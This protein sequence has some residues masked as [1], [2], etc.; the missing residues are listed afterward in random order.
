MDTESEP[1]EPYSGTSYMGQRRR[2]NYSKTHYFTRKGMCPSHWIMSVLSGR[3]AGASRR[4]THP[5]GHDLIGDQEEQEVEVRD[6][7]EERR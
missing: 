3:A 5:K 7:V 6:D 1:T 4:G 2:R